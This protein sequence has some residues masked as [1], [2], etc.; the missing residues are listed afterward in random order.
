MVIASVGQ[1]TLLCCGTVCGGG[2]Q[3]GTMP[4]V[5]LSASFWS[6]L[7]LPTSKMG[8]SGANSQVSGFGYVLGPLQVFSVRGF[9]ALFPCTG[10]LGCTVCLGPQLFLPVFLHTNVG[11][12]GPPAAASL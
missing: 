8:P 1:P 3:E 12:S 10:T 2:V 11:P 7:L 6:L 4:L 9:E 5:Q